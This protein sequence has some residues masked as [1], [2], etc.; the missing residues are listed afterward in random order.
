MERTPFRRRLKAAAI[1]LAISC[2]IAALA[3]ALVFGLWYPGM[4]RDLSGGTRLFVLVM[5]VDIALG[6]LLTLA[7]FDVRKTRRHLSM[8]LSVIGVLQLA[9][10]A[11]GLF[12]VYQARPVGMVFEIDRFRVVNASQVALEELGM[13]PPSLRQLPL[14]GPR[15]MG[16]RRPVQGEESNDA[17]F[18]SL[19]KGLDLSQRPRFWV[20][21]DQ[22]RAA[23]LATARP[24]S[25]LLARYPDQ[26]SAVLQALSAKGVDEA[27][28]RFLPLTGTRQ[29]DWVLVL[30]AK[31]DPLH[32]VP[33][34]G[35]F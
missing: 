29:G 24:L 32:P 8:D 30:D 5:S 34:D 2:A 25:V 10:L 22:T 20:P 17:L 13:A 27:Q 15:T 18:T 7:V 28:A 1:H 19:Q 3:G 16:V 26:R 14:T 12:T 31:G 33:V 21:Y 6:P 23:A 9:A 4:Y 11:Y 35:F